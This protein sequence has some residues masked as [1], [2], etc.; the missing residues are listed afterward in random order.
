MAINQTPTELL[1]SYGTL[2]L[3]DVQLSTFGRQLIGTKDTLQGFKPS[4]LNIQDSAVVATSGQTHHPIIKFTGGVSDFVTGT[5]FGLT[6]A[7]L[8]QA[9]QYE[10]SAY[11]RVSVVLQS[12]KRAWVYIDA[13]SDS[14]PL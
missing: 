8:K 14:H 3:A 12:G 1:F 13:E 7:E 2:Q 4:M 6:A 9:D 11:K 10:V 5:V